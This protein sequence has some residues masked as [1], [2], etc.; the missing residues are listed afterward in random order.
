MGDPGV[1]MWESSAWRFLRLI[2]DYEEK[3][4]VSETIKSKLQKVKEDM[5]KLK[6]G[7]KS[8]KKLFTS[9]NLSLLI[10]CWD[11]LNMCTLGTDYWHGVFPEW[12]FMISQFQIF[13]LEYQME[14]M[15]EHVRILAE[16]ANVIF[17][18]PVRGARM[19]ELLEQM[20]VV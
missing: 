7:T 11:E 6:S 13:V 15:R 1:A 14:E 16:V 8:P 17:P 9:D 2:R 20:R 18:K 12:S 19:S 5:E 4:T 3:N 10:K